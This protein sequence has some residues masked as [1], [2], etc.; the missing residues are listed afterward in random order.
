MNI[1]ESVLIFRKK[2]DTANKQYAKK[3][4]LCTQ[5]F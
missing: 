1:F 4:I 2:E 3:T 5:P